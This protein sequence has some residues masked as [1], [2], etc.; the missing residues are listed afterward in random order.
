MF[1][2]V[3]CSE[4]KRISEILEADRASRSLLYYRL[5]D[6]IDQRQI[7]LQEC[8]RRN[9]IFDSSRPLTRQT[10]HLINRCVINVQSMQ[11]LIESAVRSC[12]YLYIN[13]NINFVEDIH[14]HTHTH[15]HTHVC[16]YTQSLS[17]KSFRFD[18]FAIN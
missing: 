8:L 13:V 6:I 5:F 3:E 9:M 7:K 16:V 15:T 2:N 10:G 4:I 12:F 17:R 1:G 11:I 14:T 18:D